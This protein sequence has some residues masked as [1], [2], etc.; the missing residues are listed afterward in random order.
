MRALI[1]LVISL[2]LVACAA[3]R[4][5]APVEER[6]G[7]LKRGSSSASKHTVL[8]GDTLFGIA[9]RY[10]MDYRELASIN[11]IASPYTIYPG[12]QLKLNKPPRKTASTKS[13]GNTVASKTVTPTPRPVTKKKQTVVKKQT[14]PVPTWSGKGWRWPTSGKVVREF[15]AA[16]HKGIDID[17]KA[18]DPVYATGDGRI[19]Y[20]GNGI[21]GYGNL[22]IVKHSEVYLS[23]YGHNRDL[24]V[25]EGDNVKA[26]QKIAEKGSSATN[27]V[28]LHFEIRR[29]GKPV[30]PRKLLPAR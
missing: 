8:R 4:P 6:H 28:K 14:E 30:D 26:G 9:W 2:G 12:Q 25:T 20:A 24:L 18:G 16:T 11:G 29:E 1:V 7:E 27:S 10:G 23:A 17:G 15:S 22:L 5:R 3:E 21:V 13:S 19:V